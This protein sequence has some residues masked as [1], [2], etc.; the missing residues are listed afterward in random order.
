MKNRVRILVVVVFSE[1]FARDAQVCFPLAFLRERPE[2]AGAPLTGVEAPW[3]RKQGL[4]SYVASP[5]RRATRRYLRNTRGERSCAFRMGVKGKSCPSTRGYIRNASG[6]HTRAF[7][8]RN[9]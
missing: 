9:S 5:A 7:R 4:L 3:S 6:E 2:R 8:S 1:I